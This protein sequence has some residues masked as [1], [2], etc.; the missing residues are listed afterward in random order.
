MPKLFENDIVYEWVVPG[1]PRKVSTDMLSS[2][3][4]VHTL[5]GLFKKYPNPYATHV[6][7][8]DTINRSVDPETGVIRS[9]R[10]VGVQQGAPRWITKVGKTTYFTA[11]FGMPG[12]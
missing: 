5:I 2:Y 10:I 12:C 6:Q 11:R 4:P 1:T 8:V 7:S 9:E 3:P